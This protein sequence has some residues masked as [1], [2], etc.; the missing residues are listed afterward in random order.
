MVKEKEVKKVDSIEGVQRELERI[1][2]QKTCAYCERVIDGEVHLA[3]HRAGF[4]EGP[5]VDLCDG[6]GGNP[7]PT[8]EEIWAKI[9][10][11]RFE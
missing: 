10:Q 4:G 3:I 2:S 7:T 11:R 1:R 6:C 9:S 8:C 5:E